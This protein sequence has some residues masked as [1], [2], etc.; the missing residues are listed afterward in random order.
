[1]ITGKSEY[2]RIVSLVTHA[3]FQTAFA[4]IALCLIVI[5]DVSA[6]IFRPYDGMAFDSPD[7]Y[8]ITTVDQEGPADKAGVLVGDKLLAVDGK[9][10]GQ[11]LSRPVYSPGIEAG[12]TV[13]YQV[14]RNGQTLEIPAVMGGYFDSP[15]FFAPIIGMQFIS[16]IFWL[17]GLSL[18]VF[19][20]PGDIRARLSGLAWLVT[21]VAIASGVPGG[22]SL[23]WGSGTTM[24]L[25]WV[26]LG[27]LLLASHLYFP[28]PLFSALLRKRIIGV[29]ALIAAVLFIV[30]ILDDAV[31]KTYFSTYT[32]LNSIVYIFF[33]ISFLASLGLLLRSLFQ[34]GDLDVKRQTG[35]VLWGMGLGFMPF[36]V[37]TLLPLLLG[38]SGL[39]GAYT[40]PFLILV[41]LSYAYVIHQRKLLKVDFIVNRLIV[42][43]IMSLLVLMVSYFTLMVIA[44]LMNLPSLVPVIGSAVAVLVAVPSSSLRDRANRWV[45]HTLYG[46]YYDHASVA[47]SL[48]SRLAQ[49]PDRATLVSLLTDDL[50]RQMGIRQTALLLTDGNDLRL[51]AGAESFTVSTEDALC[52]A[53]LSVQAP[54]RAQALQAAH[55]EAAQG[56]LQEF[57]WGEL[58][59]PIIFENRLH[60]VLILGSRV[61]GDIY[62]GQDM[63]IIATVA[64][65]AALASANIQLIETL[66]GLS[67]QLVRAGEEE[68]KKVVRE[69]H[70]GVLQNLFF[71][72]QK[73]RPDAELV[74]CLDEVITTLRHTIKAQRPSALD[75]GLTPALQDL[76]DDL[77][78]VVG[79][80]GPRI[81]L[82]NNA[83]QINVS[84]EHATAIYRIAQ[85][86]LSNAIRHAHA[87]NVT[88]SLEQANGTL[89]MA[90]EDNGLG[91][92]P[93]VAPE[94]HY[95]M[96]GMRER[97]LMIGADLRVVSNRKQG[98]KIVLEY[99]PC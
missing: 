90:I 86:S 94:G 21:G 3:G 87:T 91:M 60:G 65:Q 92:S 7:F 26:A 79:I 31:F 36:L 4:L 57:A 85:E 49:A 74:G 40:A 28:A 97:A 59:V 95:G 9:P 10:V 81:V 13:I 35:I 12:D 6:F 58:F 2:P 24:K 22:A 69:L 67:Q 45:S 89:V 43:F 44:T 46:A 17:T 56:C 16:I 75:R 39:D 15:L 37:L 80:N 78:R 48:S 68:R 63:H 98:T 77:R 18:C 47:G 19:V 51:Q 76:I 54:V 99:T 72:M 42:F 11:W 96:T 33:L 50:A 14:L 83:G 66:R 27:F 8:V 1:M 93:A 55:P 52:L 64:H 70:D 25:A 34:A 88:V 20:P 61:A 23:F 32:G 5:F 53:L 73:L 62:S 82:Q 41:P 71:I 84:D 38:L 29:S 30:T